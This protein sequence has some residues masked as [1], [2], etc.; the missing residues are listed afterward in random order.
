MVTGDHLN[1][2]NLFKET[3]E[4]SFHKIKEENGLKHQKTLHCQWG[5]N[6]LIL[7]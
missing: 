7:G 6:L 2:L 4:L 5:L 1:S 3:Q